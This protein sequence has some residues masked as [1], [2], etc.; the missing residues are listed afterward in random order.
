MDNSIFTGQIQSVMQN[1]M[2][3][4]LERMIKRLDSKTQSSS[5]TSTA[6]GA[7]S[8]STSSTGEAATGDF[9]SLINAAAKKYDVDP[10]LIQAVIKAESNFNPNATSSV[11]AQGLMQLMPATARGLGV[12]DSLDP[13]QNIEGGTRF[14]SQL[15]SHYNG[16]VR[17]AVAAYNAGPG[18]V[19]KYNGVPP[20]AETQTYVNRVLG[21]I[22]SSNEWQA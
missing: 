22:S 3:T 15:L 10:T 18:A 11:G 4:L 16:N 9:A 2:L 12:T 7:Q 21:Y 8:T 13:A 1:L 14:L 20:Y 19:D 5:T 6:T 17:L